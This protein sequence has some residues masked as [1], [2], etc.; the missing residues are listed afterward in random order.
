MRIIEESTSQQ[1][2]KNLPRPVVYLEMTDGNG[3]Q[4]DEIVDNLKKMPK[5]TLLVPDI[6]SGLGTYAWR[7]EAAWESNILAYWFGYGTESDLASKIAG[8]G[9]QLGRYICGFG[10]DR[11]LIGCHGQSPYL[12]SL[13]LCSAQVSQHFQGNWKVQIETDFSKFVSRLADTVSNPPRRS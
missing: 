12:E 2:L 6:V 9:F 8:L 13:K 5:G 1:M 3:K 4:Q 7:Y 11:I 10:A